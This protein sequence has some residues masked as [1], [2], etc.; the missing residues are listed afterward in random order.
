MQRKLERLA[1]RI[2]SVRTSQG[3]TQLELAE[4]MGPGFPRTNTWLSEVEH[5][6]NGI[7]ALTLQRIADVLEYPIAY[8]T[9]EQWDARRPQW[10]RTLNEWVLLAGG[11]TLLA[12]RH[13][14]LDQT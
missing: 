14:D 3:L 13:W 4:R 1:A 11:D 10:P 12:T 9:D 5:A 6:R 2:R 8:F 7:D